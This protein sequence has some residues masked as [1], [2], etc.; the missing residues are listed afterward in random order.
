VLNSTY[1]GEDINQDCGS[2]HPRQLRETVMRERA[3]AGL[4]FDGDG[5]RILIIDEQGGAL[6]GDHI[7]AILAHDLHGR[8][9][10]RNNTV[11]GT[12]MTNLGLERELD[13]MGV[14]LE[15]VPVGD[16]HVSRRMV[17]GNMVLGGEPSGHVVFLGEGSTTGDGL[18]TAVKVLGVAVRTQ[19]HLSALRT[20][21]RKYPQVLVNVPVSRTLP[22]ETLPELAQANAQVQEQSGNHL[23]VLLRYS[24]TQPLVRVMV[25]GENEAQ[26]QWAADT[27]AQAVKR[28][29]LEPQSPGST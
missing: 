27:L 16:R 29:L 4:A 19:Q 11:V 9:Q 10:L 22:L 1:D 5:D 28:A 8:G 26:V 24:G 18:Y 14:R 21:L 2:E 17:E 25:E 20:L 23:R 13:K 15:R 7:L 3:D 12:V 6:D